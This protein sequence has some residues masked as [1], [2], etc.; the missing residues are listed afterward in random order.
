MTPHD[1]SIEIMDQSGVKSRIILAIN[2]EEDMNRRITLCWEHIVTI[3][4]PN[5]KFIL[6]HTK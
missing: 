2:I 6:M 5:Y 1:I 3:G 4:L